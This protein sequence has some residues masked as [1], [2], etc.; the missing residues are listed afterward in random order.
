M[1]IQY[2]KPSP[3]TLKILTAAIFNLICYINVGMPLA[4]IPIIVHHQ[5]GYNSIVAGMTIS[6]AYIATFVSRPSAGKWIDTKGPKSAV[7]IGLII[8]AL[9]GIFTLTASFFM[10]TPFL[11]L[12]LLILGRFCIGTSESWATTGTNLWNIGRVG[13]ENA[14]YV[15]SWNGVTSYGGMAIGAPLGF[16]LAS[17][18]GIMGGLHGIAVI[19]TVMAVIS[20]MLASTYAAIDPSPSS[21]KRLSFTAVFM[22][23][24]PAGGC[25]GLSTIG[26]G[27]IQAFVALYFIFNHWSG[28]ALTLSLFGFCFVVVRFI[29]KSAVIRFNG[30]IVSIVSLTV[31]TMGLCLLGTSSSMMMANIGASLTGCGFSLLYPALG[32]ICISKVGAENRG[33]ALAAFSLFLDIALCISGPLLGSIQYLWGYHALFIFAALCTFAGVIISFILY[34]QSKNIRKNNLHV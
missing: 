1:F 18:P 33:S 19:T 9:S 34:T 26:F 10:A 20:A 17:L 15:I 28:S 6:L 12:G 3:M 29:F 30:Y 11:A 31:E 16:Y 21:I 27:S 24:L 4:V 8:S 5:L 22:R 7:I 32:V 25:L 14:S 13:I 23:V 2:L